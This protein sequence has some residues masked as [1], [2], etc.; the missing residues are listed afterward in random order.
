MALRNLLNYKF[1][2]YCFLYPWIYLLIKLGH[3][4]HRVSYILDFVDGV[5]WE[6]I[7]RFRGFIWLRFDYLAWTL[8][9]WYSHI[10]RHIMCMVASIV[11]NAGWHWCLLVKGIISFAKLNFLDFFAGV[12]LWRKHLSSTSI[13]SGSDS[14][15]NC[16]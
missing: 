9:M 7:G 14:Y 16:I 11:G 4:I 15:Q 12:C 13:L 8:Q 5:L 2:L 6:K 10:K 3:F 1:F